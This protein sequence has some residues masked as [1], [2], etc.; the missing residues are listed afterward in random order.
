[1]TCIVPCCFEVGRVEAHICAP[2]VW[3]PVRGPIQMFLCELEFY[4][5]VELPALIYK[6]GTTAHKPKGYYHHL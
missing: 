5:T 1:M 3:S 2:T 4:N 6:M